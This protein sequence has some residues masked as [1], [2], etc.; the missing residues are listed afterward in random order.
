[1]KMNSSEIRKKLLAESESEYRDFSASLVPTFPRERVIGVRVPKLRR[2]AKELYKAGDASEFLSELPHEYLEEEHLHALII[3]EIKDFSECLFYIEKLLPHIDNW[4]SCDSLRPKCF[5]DNKE[6]LLSHVRE[7]VASPHT[8]T[9][10]F[11]IEMLMIH[12][13]D[14][15]SVGDHLDTV[16]ALHPDDY[17]LRMMI[18]WYFATAL[19]LRYS[20]AIGYIEAR[21]LDT[22]THNKAIQKACESRAVSSDRKCYLR[23]LK[24]KN[25][26]KHDA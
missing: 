4:A 8:Y 22:W 14:D 21:R 16:A 23:T 13:M 7:W 9:A 24:I 25:G 11:G 20:E 18:A 5:S 15:A 12:Y 6:G 3:C 2:L 10:R 19:T 26:G 17:Y 1:M